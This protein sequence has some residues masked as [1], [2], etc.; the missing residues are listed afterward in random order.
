VRREHRRRD[1]RAAPRGRRG[2]DLRVS[3]LALRRMRPATSAG[4]DEFR[5]AV[6]V[7]E[8]VP[9][10]RTEP[11]G[12][13]R[14][15]QSCCCCDLQMPGRGLPRRGGSRGS[16]MR[17]ARVVPASVIVLLAPVVR[18]GRPDLEVAFWVRAAGHA[19]E[20]RRA[21]RSRPQTSSP[22]LPPVRSPE[23]PPA[24]AHVA[25]A[26]WIATDPPAGPP[27]ARAAELW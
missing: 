22:E 18:D 11:G 24:R 21:T 16:A 2:A 14:P 8:H 20:A 13:S 9:A 12:A 25:R 15:R 6:A 27:R 10:G 4:D 26:V 5:I 3:P 23:S 7:E 19:E 17:A 1:L